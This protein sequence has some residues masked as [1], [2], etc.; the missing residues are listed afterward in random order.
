MDQFF[1]CAQAIPP[2]IGADESYLNERVI[3]E[4]S[5]ILELSLIG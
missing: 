5:W 3:E 4:F 2:P 1:E